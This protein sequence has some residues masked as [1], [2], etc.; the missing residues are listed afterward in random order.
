[1]NDFLEQ[2][3]KFLESKVKRSTEYGFE[4]DDADLH[5]SLFPHQKAGVRWGVKGGRRLLAASFGLGKTR[6][7]IN[8]LWV[9]QK[10]EGGKVLFVAPLGVRQEF[11]QNDG[12]AMGVNIKYCRN[13]EEVAN[14]GT[15]FII[16]NYERVRDG[17]IIPEYFTAISL[18]EGSVLRS[19]GTKTTQQF[20]DLCANVKYRFVATATPA[21]N[22]FLELINY[23]HFLG[24]MDRGQILTRF[25]QRDS[26]KAGNLTLYPHKEE[27]FWM[28][29]CGW[30][31]LIYL[32]SDLG[33]SDEGYD[34]PEL[35]VIYHELPADH[36]KA[37]E[38]TDQNGNR[39]IFQ[40]EAMGLE[41]SAAEKRDTVLPRLEK[42]KEIISE[43]GADDHWLIWHH[44]EDERR[45]IEKQIPGALSVYG[46]QDLEIREQRIMDFSDGKF[47]ILATKPELSGSGCNFQRHCHLNIFLG[48]NYDFNDFIQAIHRTQRFQQKH[49]VEVHIIHTETER[50]ILAELKKK[51][52]QHKELQQ[53]MRDIVKQYGLDQYA[54]SA[55][56]TRSIGL[57]RL[58]KSGKM[59]KAINNDCILETAQMP[60]NSVDLIVTSIPFSNHYEYT[61]SYNDFGHTESDE[62]FNAQMD[63]LI[64]N[65]LRVLKP[66]R[67]CAIHVKD[68]I[69][70]G[71]MTGYGMSTVN[72]FHMKT[73]FAFMKHGFLYNGMITVTTDV[74]SENNQTYR[75]TYGEMRKDATKMG[76]GSPEYILLFRKIPSST[77]NAYADEPVTHDKEEYSLA[78]WQL[79]A[80]S[81]WRSSGNRNLTSDEITAIVALS[82]RENGLKKIRDKFT[83]IFQEGIYDFETHV[84]IGEALGEKNRLP[85]TFSLLTPPVGN[86]F[87]WDDI[88]RMRTLNLQQANNVREKHV[89]PL[90]LD[91]VYRLIDQY[92]MP[93]EVVYDPFGGILTVP[94]CS[95]KKGRYGIACELNNG[96]W[97]D[98]INYLKEA[99]YENNVPTLFD[100]LDEVNIKRNEV[101]AGN[102]GEYLVIE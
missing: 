30:A 64:P 35:K 90:Q 19:Y 79:N 14:A 23:A 72:P 24:I 99:E 80:D 61:P 22:R 65:L 82:E 13:M 75:L 46:S 27:E 58:E 20:M 29:L 25:F 77:E 66:G 28:W 38:K 88:V 33:F 69:L 100:V 74:V 94:Y 55:K 81:N 57:P 21:P 32:P 85:K 9:I 50:A 71:K 93:G 12:P 67:V 39:Y 54:M 76:V 91:I 44:L 102:L 11:T 70:Y 2:Y 41:A 97:K 6:I 59:W 7:Q 95:V 5:P 73:T 87:T 40:H 86:S 49:T 17:Q 56:L 62:H 18:D 92:T 68:R 8:T 98:G 10:K 43:Y 3:Q 84:Q 78:R 96:Y 101:R 45:M 37:W 15:D 47:K 31:M 89:C 26:K 36:S 60:E 16:T 63:F 48:I 1:M 4:A 53:R 42:A 34:L 83:R 51:W 52:A